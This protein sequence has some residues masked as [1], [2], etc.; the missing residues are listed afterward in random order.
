MI[1][2]LGFLTPVALLDSMS[3]LPVCILPIIVLLTSE[4]PVYFTLVFISGILVVYIP[5]GLLLVFG[6]NV[7][8]DA[9]SD[10]LNNW[11]RN[12]PDGIQLILQFIIGTALLVLGYRIAGKHTQKL[13]EEPKI[14]ITTRLVFTFSAILMLTGLW[15]ALPYFAAIDQILR[16]DLNS[17]QVFLTILYYNFVFIVPLLAL[18]ITGIILGPRAKPLLEKI[19][20]WLSQFGKLFITLALYLLGII[21]IADAVSWFLGMPIFT[22]TE[23]T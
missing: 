3:M 12:E 1:E 9:V 15:G 16:A 2:I 13:E 5:F 7:V 8:I 10:Y 22:F 4:R 17:H 18:F 20:A 21:L 14:I 6:F 19:V 11:I 23:T